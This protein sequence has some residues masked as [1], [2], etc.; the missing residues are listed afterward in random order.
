M[1][2]QELSELADREARL[3]LLKSTT[4]PREKARLRC[5]ARE[6]AGDW[7]TALPSQALGLHLQGQEFVLGAK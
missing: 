6:G 3:S 7:L 5:L 2:Q 4:S 1:T